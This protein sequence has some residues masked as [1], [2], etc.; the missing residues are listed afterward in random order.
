MEHLRSTKGNTLSFKFIIL[1]VTGSI[2][3]GSEQFLWGEGNSKANIFREKAELKWECGLTFLNTIWRTLLSLTSH[4]RDRRSRSA[5]RR[6]SLLDCACRQL[7]TTPK[8]APAPSSCRRDRPAWLILT[9]YS[10][11]TSSLEQ[12]TGKIASC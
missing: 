1:E 8:T 12:F 11:M 6:S 4:V 7:A 5:M 10:A 3:N 2:M 9:L